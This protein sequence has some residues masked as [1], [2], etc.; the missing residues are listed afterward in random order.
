MEQASILPILQKIPLFEEL[1]ESDHA[2]I[3]K[4]I[5]LN[6]FPINY[7]LFSQGDPGDK[8]FIIKS[9]SV[10]IFSPDKPTEII[11]ML[12][13]NEFFGEMALFEDRP[14]SASAMTNEESEVFLLEKSDFYDL[15][16][17]NQSIASKLSEEFLNRVKT[18]QS[19]I[20]GL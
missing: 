16:L 10:K 9:G 13:P 15:V 14:R 5:N 6:Y 7:V 11:A 4:H 17:K 20:D 3:I 8:L 12:G 19:R 18:N 1:N 2:E